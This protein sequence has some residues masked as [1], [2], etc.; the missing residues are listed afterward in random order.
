MQRSA[1]GLVDN[2]L[3]DV[4]KHRSLSLTP[5]GVGHVFSVLGIFMVVLCLRVIRN[6]SYYFQGNNMLLSQN[7]YVCAR[8]PVVLF[9]CI[10]ILISALEI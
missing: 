9:H 2:S 10:W 3:L 8:S 4:A 1:V 6:Y 5:G 7:L